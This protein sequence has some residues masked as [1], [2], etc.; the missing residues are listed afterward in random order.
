M[1]YAEALFTSFGWR[2]LVL[3]VIVAVKGWDAELLVM[4][5]VVISRYLGKCKLKYVQAHA[6]VSAH[7]GAA[8]KL[9]WRDFGLGTCSK[10]EIEILIWCGIGRFRRRH[11]SRLLGWRRGGP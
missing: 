11:T 4:E 3:L 6:L 9:R 5:F 8:V 10:V 2:N 1:T 7:S